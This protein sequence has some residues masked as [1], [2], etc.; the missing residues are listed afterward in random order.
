M[1]FNTTTLAKGEGLLSAKIAGRSPDA[2]G[3]AR[4]SGRGDSGG[5]AATSSA[6]DDDWRYNVL[7]PARKGS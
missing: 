3:P 4:L 1:G 2:R 7:L 6:E 5:R